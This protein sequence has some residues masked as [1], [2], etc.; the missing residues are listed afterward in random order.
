MAI[1]LF[2]TLEGKYLKL[3]WVDGVTRLLPYCILLSSVNAHSERVRSVLNEFT[4]S[5]IDTGS[6][7]YEPYLDNLHQAGRDL[8]G[9]LFDAKDN[10]DAAGDAEDMLAQASNSESLSIFSEICVPWGFVN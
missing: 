5:H 9:A 1:S 4:N 8:Y 6:S 10:I 7:D 3:A 2:A